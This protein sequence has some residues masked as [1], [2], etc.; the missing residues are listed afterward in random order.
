MPSTVLLPPASGVSRLT[1]TPVIAGHVIMDVLIEPW[2]VLS[3]L[4]GTITLPH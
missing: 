3:A 1:L 2:L 4:G